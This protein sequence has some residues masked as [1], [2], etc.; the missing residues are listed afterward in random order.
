M[1]AVVVLAAG[2]G[3]RMRS[4]LPKVLHPLLGAPLLEHVL[5]KGEALAADLLVVVIG[6]GRDEIQAAFEGRGIIWAVQ[7]EQ[8]GTAHAAHVGVEA[9]LEACLPGT[10]PRPADGPSGDPRGTVEADLEVLILNGDLPLLEEATI[11]RLLE[12]HR[13][14][15][16]DVTILTCEKRDPTGFGRIIR[17]SD[18]TLCG[19]IEEPDADVA[20]RA[21]REVNVGTYVFR[22]SA[23]RRFYQ[24]IGRTNRQGELYLTDVVVEAARAGRRV[25][26]TS[27]GDES[28]TAQVNSRLELAAAG[29]IL[30]RRLLEEYMEAGVTI[31]DP[32]TTYIEVGVKIGPDS[33]IRPFTVI[34][35]GVEIGRG[36]E[37][38]PFAHL[39]PG[40]RLEA[41]VR[42]GNFV[43][44][45][46]SRLG[47]R[48][49][50]QHLA[51]VGD[52]EVGEDVNIGAG[53]IFANFDGKVKSKTV[54][55]DRAFI[56]SGTVLVAPVTVGE[57]AV[58]GA[59]AVVLRHRH[60]ADGEVVAGVPAK[61][62]KK[63][64]ES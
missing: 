47:R 10:A 64:M 39:R 24:A 7:E 9:A 13:Q 12:H 56:G 54:V 19:I 6:H 29:E 49:K 25:E 63:N 28:E 59:G 40:T 20:T 41:E 42:I 38:G 50:A 34:S 26:T 4:E 1:L 33:R 8:L 55:K 58:T 48:T 52:G 3:K 43:E 37:V 15:A 23:F 44:V 16:A 53:T 17:E 60:V 62:L 22:T 27:A 5:K 30:R 57:G 31:D 51:Y 45:K 61:P 32:L 14:S 21:I 36:C 18:G 46:N 35:S 2:K 11:R